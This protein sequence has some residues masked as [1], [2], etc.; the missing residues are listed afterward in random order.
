MLAQ[1]HGNMAIGNVGINQKFLLSM[2]DAQTFSPRG[3]V[4]TFQLGGEGIERE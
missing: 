3:A 1:S 2:V 4:S